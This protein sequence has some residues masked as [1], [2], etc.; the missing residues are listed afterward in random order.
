MDDDAARR[1]RALCDRGMAGC[2]AGD[3]AAVEE[4][5]LELMEALDFDY[6]EAALSL[7]RAYDDSLGEVRTGRF[8]PA[9][10]VLGKLREACATPTG[11]ATAGDG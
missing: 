10:A 9:R 3:A 6:E 7:F 1:V 4:V 2:R 11:L 5:L 8:E